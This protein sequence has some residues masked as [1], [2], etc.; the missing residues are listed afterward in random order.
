M[1]VR[2]ESLARATSTGFLHTGG[3]EAGGERRKAGPLLLPPGRKQGKQRRLFCP[4]T[5]A[6][7]HVIGRAVHYRAARHKRTSSRC[8]VDG[9]GY[10]NT[11]TTAGRRG[12][13]K[14]MRSSGSGP[15][16]G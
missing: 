15:T 1:A 6:P 11:T 8:A 14:R 4:G 16:T 3:Y 5:L 2:L 9:Q 7:R 12:R 13:L 10:P